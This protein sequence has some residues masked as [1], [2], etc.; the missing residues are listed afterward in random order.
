MV[1]KDRSC[2]RL[3]PISTSQLVHILPRLVFITVH[4]SHY[5]FIYVY[6]TCPKSHLIDHLKIDSG[7]KITSVH[8][9]LH[10]KKSFRRTFQNTRW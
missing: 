9:V 8:D 1:T 2:G 3:V 6:M 10:S 7:K 5:Y 4:T